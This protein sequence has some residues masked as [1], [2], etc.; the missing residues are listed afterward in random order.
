M[1]LTFKD[2]SVQIQAEVEL[3]SAQTDLDMFIKAVK[4][5][6]PLPSATY[7]VESYQ[8]S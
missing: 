4:S 6:K 3:I 7:S 2:T 8:S 5:G 1:S